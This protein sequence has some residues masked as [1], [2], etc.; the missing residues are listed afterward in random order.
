MKTKHFIIVALLAFAALWH[1]PVQAQTD[2]YSLS[3]KEKEARAEVLLKMNFDT[4]MLDAKTMQA[5][6]T[7]LKR[8]GMYYDKKAQKEIT[9]EVWE[10]LGGLLGVGIGAGVCVL[11]VPVGVVMIV[12]GVYFFVDSIVRMAKNKYS[13][14]ENKSKRLFE[15]ANDVIPDV[16]Q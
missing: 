11:S 14:Y 4:M 5:Y 8:F 10:M 1:E 6:N 13:E 16:S 9:R 3:K 7:E 15:K 2:F 12:G